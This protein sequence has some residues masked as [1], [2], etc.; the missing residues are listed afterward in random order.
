MSMRPLLAA[1][2]FALLVQACSGI[3]ATSAVP[4][5]DTP[6][7]LVSQDGVAVAPGS[8]ARP[9][10]ILLK[11]KR[12]GG[13]GGCN[14]LMTTYTLDGDKLKF[15]L[16]A[17]SRMAC[18]TGMKEE[19]GFVSLLQRVVRWQIE[20]RHLVLFDGADKAVL[21]FEVRTGL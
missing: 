6:W 9:A 17:A 15:G 5:E 2:P 1:L 8:R 4:L 10:E 11:D 7:T 13:S 12:L 14:R 3:S 21:R 19:A 16:L 18:A 20:G